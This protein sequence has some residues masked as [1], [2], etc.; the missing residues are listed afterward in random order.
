MQLNV[1][2]THL[3]KHQKVMNEN[4]AFISTVGG[5]NRAA[6]MQKIWDETKDIRNRGD[7]E[8]EFRK[9]TNHFTQQMVNRFL[10]LP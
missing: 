7:R 3:K 4:D 8:M 9:R 1:Y 6:E 5:V 10:V 2:G